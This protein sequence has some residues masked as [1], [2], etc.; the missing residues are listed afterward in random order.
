M[1]TLKA[2]FKV[3]EVGGQKIETAI[4]SLEPE[5]QKQFEGVNWKKIPYEYVVFATREESSQKWSEVDVLELINSAE[6][7]NAKAK[8]YQKVTKPFRPDTDTP[9]YKRGQLIK[10]LVALGVAAEIAEQ[11]VDAMLASAAPVE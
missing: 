2:T 9:E 6:K 3:E 4:A 7:A 5:A 1:K 10:N 11:Q 8:E